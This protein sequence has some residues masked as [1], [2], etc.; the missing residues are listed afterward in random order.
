M[1]PETRI[2][3]PKLQGEFG[4]KESSDQSYAKIIFTNHDDLAYD[5]I[6]K[7]IK[8]IDPNLNAMVTNKIVSITQT[9]LKIKDRTKQNVKREIRKKLREISTAFHFRQSTAPKQGA[10]T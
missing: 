5:N 7:W 1:G 9:R 4:I 3:Q 2:W 8:R 10:F 6:L